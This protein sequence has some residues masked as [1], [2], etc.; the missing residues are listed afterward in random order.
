[1]RAAN[2]GSSLRPCCRRRRSLWSCRWTCG[3]HFT[4]DK[5]RPNASGESNAKTTHKAIPEPPQQ[6][7]NIVLRDRTIRIAV[8]HDVARDLHARI[9]D[10]HMRTGDELLHL[11]FALST[12]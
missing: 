4:R 3:P 12:E 7:P 9:T 1:L 6:S 11:I 8:F 2:R 5:R 10:E